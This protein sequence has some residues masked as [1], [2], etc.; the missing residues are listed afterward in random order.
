MLVQKVHTSAVTSSGP[1]TVPKVPCSTEY[2]GERDHRLR[3]RSDLPS[4]DFPFPFPFANVAGATRQA[5]HTYM[6]YAGAV[7]TTPGSAPACVGPE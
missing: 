4:H 3:K 1:E 5:D 2:H 7:A 6:G